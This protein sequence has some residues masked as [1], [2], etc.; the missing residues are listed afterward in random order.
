MNVH[1]VHQPCEIVQEKIRILEESQ[2]AQINKQG[3]LVMHSQRF[4][5]QERNVEDCLDK[6]KA[7]LLRVAQPP[8]P[9]KKTRPSRAAKQ[10]RL[11]DKKARSDVKS[12]RREPPRE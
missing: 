3:E 7:M 2:H 11:N 12:R 1:A 8:K 10:R 9:R 6:L 4:R 5:D